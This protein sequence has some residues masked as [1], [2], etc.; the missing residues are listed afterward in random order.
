MEFLMFED[1]GVVSEAATGVVLRLLGVSPRQARVA[2]AMG[3][4]GGG[5]LVEAA[6]T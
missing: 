4:L 2:K 3:L 1:M 5:G 6:V